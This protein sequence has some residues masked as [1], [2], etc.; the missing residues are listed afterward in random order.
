MRFVLRKG[1]L[2]A[3]YRS[4]HD[5]A[6]R[7]R[8]AVRSRTEEALLELIQYGGLNGRAE[9]AAGA[10]GPRK[11]GKRSMPSLFL[12]LLDRTHWGWHAERL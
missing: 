2:V 12:P 7:V 4:I 9:V 11:T 8:G 5:C 3:L 1:L 6:L 10:G